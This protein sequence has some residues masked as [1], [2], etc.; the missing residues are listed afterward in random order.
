[1]K[2]LSFLIIAALLFGGCSS[3]STIRYNETR[4]VKKEEQP[5]KQVVSSN[6]KNEQ[7]KN[8]RG[9][10]KLDKEELKTLGHLDSTSSENTLSFQDQDEDMPDEESVDISKFMSN[11]NENE[12]GGLSSNARDRVLMKVIEYL[13]T[14]YKYGG[15]TKSGIDCSAFTQTVYSD[16]LSLPLLRTARD[17]YTQGQIIVDRTELKFGDLVFFNT[18]RVKPGHVGIYIGNNCFV[19]ASSKH[20]V[21][22]STLDM[23]YYSARFMGGRRITSLAM[24]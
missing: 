11:L 19:H 22:V 4:D 14:P 16:A 18:R 12:T 6:K 17:Q 21:I 13:N 7:T 10:Y 3:F 20:G 15:T 24:N 8:V 2:H 9:D 1:M 23:D 5:V